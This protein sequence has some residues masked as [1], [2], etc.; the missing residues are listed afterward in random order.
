LSFL[1]YE[2]LWQEPLNPEKVVTIKLEENATKKE[3]MNTGEKITR[4]V[5]LE[6][7]IYFFLR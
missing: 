3:E 5:S 7:E 2:W 4:N 6:M 1:S